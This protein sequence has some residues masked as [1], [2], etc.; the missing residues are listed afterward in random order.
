MDGVDLVAEEVDAPGAILVLAGEDVDGLAA[1][2]EE[3]AGEAGVVALVLL[4]DE[5]ADELVARDGA[6]ALE[7]DDH[8]RVGFDR[9]DAVDA[10]D[11]GDNDDVVALE[12]GLCGRVAHAVDL[13][14]DL[15]VFFYVGVGAG[16]V[17]F[18][19]VVVVVADKVFDGV[20]GEEALHFVVELGGEGLVRRQDQG[21][22]LGGLD[23]L[24]D[25]EG[26]AGAGDAEEDL[27]A[28]GGADAGDEVADGGGLV[29]GGLV[30][31]LQHEAARAGLGRLVDGLEGAVGDSG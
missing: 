25:G 28:L 23:D 1:D 16:D 3:A 15:G 22:A 13:L 18:G 9:A 8:A 10:G 12:Q 7:A 6:A 14:V 17:G 24:G 19:L 27:I 4:F 2:A 29:A 31:G 30:V 20:V 5:G 26:L 11:G 21:G